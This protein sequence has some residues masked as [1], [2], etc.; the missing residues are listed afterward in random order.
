MFK[1]LTSDIKEKQ[2][3][4]SIMLSLNKLKRYLVNLKKFSLLIYIE[5]K[6]FIRAVI[7]S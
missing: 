7:L 2:S 4:N 5:N 3:N 1:T 6:Q